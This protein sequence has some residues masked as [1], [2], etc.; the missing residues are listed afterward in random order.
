MAIFIIIIFIILSIVNIIY[1]AFG[2]YLRYGWMV[3]G[4]S[5]PSDAYLAM[6]RIG[7]ILALVILVIALFSGSLLF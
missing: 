4:E 7:S 2:W 3:K 5:E 6:S 1:P